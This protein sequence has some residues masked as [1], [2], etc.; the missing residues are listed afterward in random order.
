MTTPPITITADTIRPLTLDD[1][2]AERAAMVDA[3]RS[4]GASGVYE[5]GSVGVPGISDLDVVA[6]FPDE[7][8][9]RRS[10]APVEALLREGTRGFLH[11]PWAMRE[12]HRRLLPSLFAVRQMHDLQGGPSLEPVQTPMQRLLWN[13]EACASVLSTLV[14]RRRLT[15]RSAVCLLNG[16]RYNVE[17][18]ALDQVAAVGS[19]EFCGRIGRLRSSWFELAAPAREQE[20][21]ELWTAAEAV[22][23]DL[24]ASYGQRVASFLRETPND[25]LMRVPGANTTYFFTNGKA[26]RLLLTQPLAN[27][28]TLPRE[29]GPLFQ[30]LAEPGLGLDRWLTVEH[31]D[32]GPDVRLEPKFALAAHAYARDNAAYLQ[33]LLAQRTP[34]LLLGGG[35]LS[36][37]R[38]TAAARVMSLLRRVR[39]KLLP[40]PS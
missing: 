9:L 12:R 29:L 31:V 19:G 16:V 23:R 26:P 13:V 40:L 17:L 7:L 14:S 36:H 32:A 1:Y 28:V 25:L 34:F 35:T 18:A 21:I 22:L 24:L 4:C 27:V 3:L 11:A 15:T 33:D 37:V 39:A 20:T 38:T 30:L 8:D 2:A 5:I 10:F 6:C